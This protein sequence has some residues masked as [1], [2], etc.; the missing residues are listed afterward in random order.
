MPL[1]FLLCTSECL[2]MLAKLLRAI[3]L[4]FAL[5]VLSVTTLRNPQAVDEIANKD[6]VADAHACFQD[7]LAQHQK[8]NRTTTPK[9][10]SKL[11]G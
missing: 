8:S 3:S 9:L 11:L 1:L 10:L 4:W 6:D 7:C 2:Q 5:N